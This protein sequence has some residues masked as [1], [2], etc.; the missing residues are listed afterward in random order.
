MSEL[1]TVSASPHITKPD[2]TTAGVMFD[3]LIAL[4]PC[5]VAAILYFGYHVAINLFV[6]VIGCV[7]AEL[8]FN[9][10]RSGKWNREGI[11]GSSIFDFS[12]V[13]TAVILTLNLPAKIKMDA[14]DLNIYFKGSEHIADNIA[15]SFDT[16]ILCLLGSVFAIVIVKMMFGG[17]GKN[18]A[19]PAAM[20]RIF[21]FAFAPL[22][23]VQ[24]IGIIGE[25][26]TGATWLSGDKAT[27]AGSLFMQL[28]TGN[29]GSAAVGETCVIAILIGY[30]DLSVR[31]VIDWRIPLILVASA[32]LFALV[33]DGLI[34]MNL[35]GA[36]LMNNMFAHILSGGLIFGAVYMATDY[37]TSPNTF[38]GSAVFA[39]GIA[40]ITMLIRVFAGYP[41]GMSFAIVIMN[42]ASPLI[43]KFIVPKPFGYVREKKKKIKKAEELR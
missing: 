31:K 9:L 43:D 29:T 27:N 2:N 35:S 24:T 17:I 37:S 39:V 1:Y 3:V 8:L 11:A 38:A 41:E 30:V 20:G 34:S 19:N 13:V 42:I 10:I 4:L 12:A 6:C 5:V 21:L 28:F 16:V 18:F 32:G 7:G 22:A 26:S 14:W 25:V 33:F 15:F 40:L 23:A 36:R